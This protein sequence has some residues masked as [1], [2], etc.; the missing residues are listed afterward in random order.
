MFIYEVVSAVWGAIYYFRQGADPV[1]PEWDHILY[2]ERGYSERLRFYRAA[3]LVQL[4]GDTG[5]YGGGNL[6]AGPN[7]WAT[8][9]VDIRHEK[10]S[11]VS[12]HDIWANESA[13]LGEVEGHL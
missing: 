11:H 4:G 2:Y 8:R 6:V 3:I 1:F 5:G 7:L 10:G 13:S 12:G 9:K